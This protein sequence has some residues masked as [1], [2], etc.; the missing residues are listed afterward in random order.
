M[1]A[2]T[3]SLPRAHVARRLHADTTYVDGILQRT[4]RPLVVHVCSLPTLASLNQH[5]MFSGTTWTTDRALLDTYV[6]PVSM[7]T[8]ILDTR[9]GTAFSPAKTAAIR[10]KKRCFVS[11]TL[12]LHDKGTSNGQR[13]YLMAQQYTDSTSAG[14]ANVVRAWAAREIT[15]NEHRRETIYAEFVAEAGNCLS[16][17]CE[18][19]ATTGTLYGE[20]TMEIRDCTSGLAA[21]TSFDF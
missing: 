14:T 13:Y 17:Y 2:T 8:N 6:E 4:V 3:V 12:G 7:A 5:N 21:A 20:M 1:S 11:L 19:D 15:S 9:D 16:A 18:T 10:F